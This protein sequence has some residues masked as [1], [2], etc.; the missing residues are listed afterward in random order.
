MQIE[1]LANENLQALVPLVLELWPLCIYE[2]EHERFMKM[3]HSSGSGVYLLREDEEYIGFISLSIRTDYVEGMIHSPVGY[4]EGVYIKPGHRGKGYGKALVQ[5]AEDWTLEKGCRQ[6]GSDTEAF[7][8]GSIEFH[9]QLG[10]NIENQ[11]VCFMKNL[12]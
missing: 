9:R 3:I 4:I 11:I 10:F 12:N 8:A 5:C 1:P 6:L 7:N 2:E